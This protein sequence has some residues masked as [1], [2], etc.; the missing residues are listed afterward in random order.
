MIRYSGGTQANQAVL[1]GESDVATSLIGPAKT[2]LDTGKVRLIGITGSKRHELLPSVPAFGESQVPEVR[3]LAATGFGNFWVGLFAPAGTPRPVVSLLS[4][5]TEHALKDPELAVSLRRFDV[6]VVG[7]KPGEF[8]AFF[9]RE[10]ERW[11]AIAKEAGIQ[12]Q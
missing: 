9:A 1:A 12:P 6:E 4:E 10:T 2:A 5:A 11:R 3:E 8:A 7:S